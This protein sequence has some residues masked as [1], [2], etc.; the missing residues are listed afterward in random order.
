MGTGHRNTAFKPIKTGIQA[1]KSRSAAQTA[2][3]S[4]KRNGSEPRSRKGSFGIGWAIA[5]LLITAGGIAG[6]GWMA[7]QLMVNPLG[8]SWVNRFMPDWIPT[9]VAGLQPPQTLQ[10]IQAGIQRTGKIPGE[11]LALGKNKSFLDGKST[12]IDVLIPLLARSPNAPGN[13]A[14]VVELRVY[15]SVPLQQQKANQAPLFQLV[16]Q[17]SIVGPE[18]SFVIAPL[19]NADSTSQGTAH[20]LPLTALKRLGD[21]AP[22]QGTWLN[23]TGTWNRRDETVAYGQIIHYNPGRFHLGMMLEWSST[24]GQDPVWQEISGSKPPELVINQTIGMEPKFRIYQVKPRN[25]LPDPIQLEPISLADPA[26]NSPT[27]SKALLLAR[28]GLWS[29]GLKWLQSYQQQ[30][31][32]GGKWSAIAQAQMNLVQLHAQI[33]QTQA[34]Q[35]WAS[36]NQQVLANLLDGRWIRALHVFNDSSENSLET[37]ALLRADAGQL[38]NRVEAALQVD[39]NQPEVKTWGALLIASQKGA[40][41]AIVWLKKQPKTTSADITQV[42]RLIKRLEITGEQ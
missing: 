32:K 39:P 37:A 40:A 38:Q 21:K 10:A 19:I 15:Q 22:T 8:L 24:T 5:A 41:A 23:L 31:G 13:T 27:Y 35:S 26:L 1:W 6:S 17:L 14:Y 34:D 4:L 42:N 29:T 18:E 9:P 25:F 30:Q 33:T 7:I 2:S 11:A 12:V 28:N 20:P 36:P 16:K 3:T